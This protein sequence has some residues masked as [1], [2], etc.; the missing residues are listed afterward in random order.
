[1]KKQAFANFSAYNKLSSILENF[2]AALG[3]EKML[4][5][6]TFY[7]LFTRSQ[8]FNTNITMHKL[9]GWMTSKDLAVGRFFK[10]ISFFFN[11]IL[12]QNTL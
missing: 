6:A 2:F 10:S 9:F 4:S 5:K 7:L 11:V 1:M 8:Y 12:C 3:G